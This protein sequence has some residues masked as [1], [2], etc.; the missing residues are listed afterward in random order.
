[1]LMAFIRKKRIKGKIYYYIVE[2]TWING[3]CCQ[4]VLAYLG[5]ADALLKRIKKEVV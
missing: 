2:S 5:T 3:Q 4:K 1:M